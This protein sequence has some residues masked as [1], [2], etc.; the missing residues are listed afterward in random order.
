MRRTYERR[1]NLVIQAASEIEGLELARPK[2][3]F[4]FMLNVSRFNG[5]S[6]DF[7][8]KLL[9]QARVSLVPGISFGQCAEGWVRIT[10][11]TDE[12]Q[13]TKGLDRIGEFI[14]TTYRA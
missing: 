13:L 8:L 5:D 11:A 6:S 9:Q 10:F 4:Y 7:A 3:A 12:S 1:R 2:G 14:R